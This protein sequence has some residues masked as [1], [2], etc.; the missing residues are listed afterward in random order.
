MSEGVRSPDEELTSRIQ[1]NDMVTLWEIRYG[2]RMSDEE[3][4]TTHGNHIGD[5]FAH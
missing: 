3:Q 4:E 5:T 2:S 1:G